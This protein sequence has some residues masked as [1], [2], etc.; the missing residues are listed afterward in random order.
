MN[1][2]KN[3]RLTP[4]RREEMA[5]AVIRGGLSKAEASRRYGVCAKIVSRRLG[6][7]PYYHRWFPRASP[8]RASSLIKRLSVPWSS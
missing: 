4:L 5:V 7:C 3:A 2:H 6:I 8:T 1:T